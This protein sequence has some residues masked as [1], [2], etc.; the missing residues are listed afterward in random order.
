MEFKQVK[1]FFQLF[2][3]R[4]ILVQ[5]PSK[6]G[7]AAR[8]ELSSDQALDKSST[9]PLSLSTRFV[10]NILD[11]KLDW[12]IGTKRG[13][14]A[15]MISQVFFV[16]WHRETVTQI[17]LSHPMIVFRDRGNELRTY[18]CKLPFAAMGVSPTVR[19]IT[20]VVSVLIE[21]TPKGMNA[22]IVAA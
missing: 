13:I 9:C 6:I 2:A 8:R 5:G 19:K 15:A 22:C 1:P 10:R 18:W 20:Q 11:F 7:P 17:G 12:I 4:Q 16:V 3:K 14:A 21:H